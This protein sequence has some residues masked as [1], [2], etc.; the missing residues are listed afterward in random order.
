MSS[1]AYQVSTYPVC[2]CQALDVCRALSA[3]DQTLGTWVP[4]EHRKKLL[5]CLDV[6]QLERDKV[7]LRELWQGEGDVRNQTLAT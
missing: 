5:L 6:V 1:L 7:R 3:A 4:V 2:A